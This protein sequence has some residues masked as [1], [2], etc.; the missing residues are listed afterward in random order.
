M[1]IDGGHSRVPGLLTPYLFSSSLRCRSCLPWLGSTPVWSGSRGEGE[2]QSPRDT[3]C[4]QTPPSRHS[5]PLP[6]T[7]SRCFAL[8]SVSSQHSCLSV[9]LSHLPCLPCLSHNEVTVNNLSYLSV[10]CPIYPL[11]FRF[12]FRYSSWDTFG[13]ATEASLMRL[14]LSLIFVWQCPLYSS[15][16]YF[17]IFLLPNS[18]L[19]KGY[20]NRGNT[21]KSIMCVCVCVS[22][23]VCVF[24][25]QQIKAK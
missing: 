1:L 21:H 10:D 3:A 24:V 6:F 17:C 18:Y 22:A 13:K 25:L 5:A 8:T 12:S 19:Q 4:L 14:F 16:F 20:Q 15:L 9:N 7:S 11:Q 23:C 2:R